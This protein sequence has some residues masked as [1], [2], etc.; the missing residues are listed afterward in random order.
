MA[1]AAWLLHSLLHRPV[2]SQRCG[3]L[4]SMHTPCALKRASKLAAVVSLCPLL[5]PSPAA[6]PPAPRRVFLVDLPGA[7]QGS[8]AVGE[9][10][11]ALG[12]PD[13]HRLEVLDQILNGFG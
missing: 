4:C 10:G 13:E 12:D 8:V 5:L 1:A 9:P 3:A 7:S 6:P 2:S 11:I